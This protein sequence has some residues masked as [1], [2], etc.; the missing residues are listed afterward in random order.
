LTQCADRPRKHLGSQLY[1]TE[2]DIASA[3]ELSAD[4]TIKFSS[5]FKPIPYFEGKENCTFTLR[6]PRYYF[7][8]SADDSPGDL[9]TEEGGHERPERSPNYSFE[10]ICRRREIWGTDIYTDDSD[11]IAAAVH[12]GWI[13]GAFGDLDEDIRQLRVGPDQ[14]ND[15]DDTSDTIADVPAPALAVTAVP[16]KPLPIP[17][18]HDAHI[19]LLILPPLTQYAS[20]HRHH[21]H[22]RPWPSHHDGMSFA[23]HRIDFVREGPIAR[24]A[25]RGAKARKARILAEERSRREMAALGLLMF[26]GGGNRI[27][28][29]TG[30]KDVAAASSS[31]RV[32]RNGANGG[33][34]RVGA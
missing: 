21:M 34:I 11:P 9:Q 17:V 2:V 22:S 5:K 29:E 23:I 10:E 18:G 3:S 26:S 30:R 8:S 4:A 6:V 14:S 19:T 27:G 1:S 32:T 24:F 28:T 7:G 20:T 31:E 15:M 13:Q 25:E 12:A 33:I 16:S